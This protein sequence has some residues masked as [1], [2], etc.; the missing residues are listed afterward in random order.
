M[1][2]KSHSKANKE[3]KIRNFE[4]AKILAQKY[5]GECLSA[6][7]SICKGKNALKFRCQNNHIFFI[8]VDMIEN[9]ETIS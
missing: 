6:S 4:K 9:A 1:K 7:Y 3:Q 2:S 5:N 8:P